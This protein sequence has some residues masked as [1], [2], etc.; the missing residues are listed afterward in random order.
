LQDL[1]YKILNYSPDLTKR[2]IDDTIRD[3]FN[4]WAKVTPLTFK[5]VDSGKV[6]INIKFVK[7]EHGD[8]YPF[9]RRGGTLAHA[10]YPQDN[11]QGKLVC[12]SVG[13]KII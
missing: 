4:E 13:L 8:G 11:S 6:D 7:E 12:R 1:T 3:A 5:K 10:F 2:E 9:D